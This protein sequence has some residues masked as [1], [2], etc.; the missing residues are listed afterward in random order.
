[1]KK[2]NYVSYMLYGILASIG[3]LLNFDLGIHVLAFTTWC[4]IMCLRYLVEYAVY[5]AINADK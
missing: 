3:M 4:S 5:E 1:M 2:P